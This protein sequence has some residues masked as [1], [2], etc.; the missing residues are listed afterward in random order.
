MDVICLL[1]RSVAFKAVNE[2]K[3][4]NKEEKKLNRDYCDELLC[5]L[6]KNY[7]AC[8]AIRCEL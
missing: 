8:E 5:A 1:Y 3:T 6:M 4:R 7:A 2:L